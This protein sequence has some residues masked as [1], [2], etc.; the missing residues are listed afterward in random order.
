MKKPSIL[1][2]EQTHKVKVPE[3][4]RNAQRKTVSRQKEP[5][6]PE[7]PLSELQLASP[8]T[9]QAPVKSP[10]RKAS[11]SPSRSQRSQPTRKRTKTSAPASA[12]AASSKAPT[13]TS[14]ETVSLWENNSPILQRLAAL[15]E[16]NRLLEEQ[17]RRL[18]TLPQGKRP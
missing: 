18:N 11:S 3:G 2:Q 1:R 8:K 14:T 10:A 9:Q 15:Q 5:Q 4:E 6:A 13:G 12:N 16:R 17:L 7:Q